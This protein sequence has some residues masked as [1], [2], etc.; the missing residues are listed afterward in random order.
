MCRTRKPGRL[1]GSDY[2][3]KGS[4]VHVLKVFALGACVAM[5]G[6]AS[7]G[8]A[9]KP[10]HES[11]TTCATYA[12][13]TF[14]LKMTGLA[15]TPQKGPAG[16]CHFTVNGVGHAFQLGVHVLASPPAALAFLKQG[17]DVLAVAPATGQW[18]T[19]IGTK[20]WLLTGDGL[21]GAYAVRGSE[22][23]VLQWAPASATL[24]GDQALATLK[25]LIA[26]VPK[27]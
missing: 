9:T 3:R 22:I 23:F 10:F 17:Y 5:L 8:A 26:K 13:P 7:A 6:A 18:E 24:T 4:A 11:A 1:A 25:A 16:Q 20:A 19:G 12:S 21:S 2:S 15:A 27:K 14:V